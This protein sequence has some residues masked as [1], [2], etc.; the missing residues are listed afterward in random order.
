MDQVFFF[1]IFSIIA[2]ITIALLLLLLLFAILIITIGREE[3]MNLISKIQGEET[4]V[5]NSK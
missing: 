3:T 4:D 1:A 5:K 2:A